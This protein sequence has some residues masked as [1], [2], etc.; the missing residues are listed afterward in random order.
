VLLHHS[1]R[2]R[3]LLQVVT[4]TGAALVVITLLC[5]TTATLLIAR[6]RWS[7]AFLVCATAASMIVDALMKQVFHRARPEIIP[8]YFIGGYSF[9]SG[10]TMNTMGFALAVTIVFWNTRWRWFAAFSSLAWAVSV[11]VSRVYLGVHFPS[12][13]LG[14][15]ALAVAVVAIVWLAFWVELEN[16]GSGAGLAAVERSPAAHPAPTPPNDG[17]ALSG[18]TGTEDP[19]LSS[20]E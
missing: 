2:V 20:E 14:G 7:A 4:A 9:P 1:D 15:W 10:H 19:T 11:G 12:D 13:V 5:A 16:D 3:H 8:H 18:S 17:D 6:L